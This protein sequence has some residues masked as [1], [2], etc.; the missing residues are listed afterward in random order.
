MRITVAVDVMGGDHGASVTVPAALQVLAQQP[1]LHLL[2]V[3]DEG[4][5][6]PLIAL[7]ASAQRARIEIVHT[8]EFVTMSDKVSVALRNKKQSSMRLAVNAVRDGQA[9]ACVSA[10]NTGALMAIGRF[11]LKTHPGIDRPAIMTALPTQKG[12]AHMLDLGANVDSDPHHLV[13]FAEMG[14][15]VA[16]ALDGYG[17]SNAGQSSADQPRVGLLNIGEEEIKGNDFIKATHELLRASSLNYIGYVEGDGIFHG[18]ADVVVCDGFVGNIALKSSEGV[19]KMMGA[20][21]KEQIN[22]NWLTKLLGLLAYPIWK[23]LKQEMDP[24]RYNGAS[25]VGLTGI[26]VKSH[27]SAQIDS[28]AQALRV[29]IKE[30]EKDIPGLLARHFSAAEAVRNELAVAA[31][32]ST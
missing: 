1:D 14:S 6:T 3:G 30:V 2:L 22:R 7:V 18:D 27:G 12:H 20:K 5:I 16:Q 29:A 4:L 21:I 13:Q 31:E 23:G 32:S 24:G 19:A 10:G 26:V 17:Q 25:L 9:Q 28:F 8:T 15:L 11:V